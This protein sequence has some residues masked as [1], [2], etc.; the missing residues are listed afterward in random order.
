MGEYLNGINVLEVGVGANEFEV[1][2]LRK[3]TSACDLQDLLEG[4]TAIDGCAT[5]GESQRG[6]ERREVV[7]Q[8][9]HSTFA[10]GSV[11]E[12]IAITW[13]LCDL[14]YAASPTTLE[15]HSYFSLSM[16]H[17]VRIR[18]HLINPHV[19]DELTG[20]S[21][22]RTRKVAEVYRFREVSLHHAKLFRR[23]VVLTVLTY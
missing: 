17:H 20:I 8:S 2:T 9:L 3:H 11:D 4:D 7:A 23:Q 5:A 15:R 21:E 12:L 10:P 13:V 22:E 14:L 6:Y 1:L 19:V 16:V 18:C